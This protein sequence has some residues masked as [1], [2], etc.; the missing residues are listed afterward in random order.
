M[1]ANT[2]ALAAM[3]RRREIGVMKAVGVRAG[4]VLRQMLLESAIVGLVGGLIGVLFITHA[5]AYAW[6]LWDGDW[7]RVR[8]M[9]WQAPITG[10]LFILLPLAHSE[11]LRPDAG[12]SLVLYYILA[13]IFVL[14]NLGVILSYRASGNRKANTND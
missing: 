12:A 10:L 7:I 5:A 14:A 8:P 2:A 9:F 3:E 11:D 1:I 4:Q 13:G 6:T